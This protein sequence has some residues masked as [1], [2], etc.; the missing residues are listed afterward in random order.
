MERKNY[1]VEDLSE[2]EDKYIIC[3]ID[4]AFLSSIRKY[5]REKKV[6]RYSIDDINIQEQLPSR[7]D[8][9]F[10]PNLDEIN[11]WVTSHVYSKQQQDF[12]V[13][14]LESLAMQFGLEKYLK[15]LTYNEKLVFFLLNIQCLS[16]NKVAFCL[17]LTRQ[18]VWSRMKTAKNKIKEAKLKYGRG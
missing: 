15:T 14:K 4:K 6:K 5:S 12:C 1:L 18:A 2:D 3:A 13:Q 10:E 9:Y 16:V 11:S 7:E 8:A 17:D